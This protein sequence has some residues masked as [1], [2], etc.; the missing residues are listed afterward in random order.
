MGYAVSDTESDEAHL[1]QEISDHPE[2]DAGLPKRG[3][4]GTQRKHK[5][6]GEKKAGKDRAQAGSDTELIAC[7]D[8]DEIVEDWP[9]VTGPLSQAAREDCLE[10]ARQVMA[11][12]REIAQVHKKSVRDVMLASGL[13]VRQSRPKNPMNAYRQWYAHMHPN[14]GI[15]TSHLATPSYVSNIRFLPDTVSYKEYGK[16]MNREFHYLV[17]DVHDDAERAELLR[18]M[19][20]YAEMVDNGK[21]TSHTL[22]SIV[23]RMQS[24][25]D[26]FTRLVGAFNQLKSPTYR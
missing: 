5:G 11:V 19:M 21:D 7:E 16:V 15:C 8:D 9:K 22:R 17:D 4:Q 24:A 26:Q 12:A 18:L 13:G 10:L 6:K 20:E 3:K 23:A 14:D 25:K 2:T 1:E